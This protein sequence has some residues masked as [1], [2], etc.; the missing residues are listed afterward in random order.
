MSK[1]HIILSDA[2]REHLEGLT[3]NGSL[4][5]QE[6]KRILSLL[7]LDKGKTCQE[8]SSFVGVCYQSV[9]KLAHTYQSDGLGCVRD[10]ERSGRPSKFSYIDKAKVTDLACSD[11]PEGHNQ[12]LLRLLADKLVE[13]EYIDE[14]SYSTVNAKKIRVL[15][16]NLNTYNFSFFYEVFDAHTTAQ[17]ADRFEFIYTPKS[18]FWLNM[19]E[20]EFSALSRLCLNRRISNINLLVKEV[21]AF[22][23]ERS[24]KG[25][26]INWSFDRKNA[27]KKLKRH[28]NKVNS[29]N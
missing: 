5:A 28:N 1:S 12:W 16:D 15:L 4:K 6:L 13:L 21:F 23:K 19:I 8:V 18:A 27:R 11:S 10:K 26:L 3:E 25:V 20:N 7:Q 2:E 29:N 14:I 9:S 22:F 24:D 17:L